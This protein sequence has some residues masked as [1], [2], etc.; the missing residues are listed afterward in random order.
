MKRIVPAVL[1]LVLALPA[2]AGAAKR[3]Y[4]G[5]VDAASGS[6]AFVLK[7]K[8]K[9]G[10]RRTSVRTFKFR[11]VPI[12]CDAESG[13][14]RGRLTFEMRVKRKRFGAL[15]EDDQGSQLRVKGALK[16]R[17]KR[18]V[19]T[20]RIFG[21]VPLDPDAHRGANCATGKLRWNAQRV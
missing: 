15:A 6:I 4:A 21:A 17:G 12:V 20:L 3:D 9:K 14:T 11:E 7:T 18:V 19:G 16:Q 2:H 1:V 8:V 13:T 5:A 10:K